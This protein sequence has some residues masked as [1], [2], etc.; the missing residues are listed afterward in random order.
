M[1]AFPA[2]HVLTVRFTVA[3]PEGL[4]TTLAATCRLVLTSCSYLG[5]RLPAEI[6]LPYR[7]SVH[8]VIL[9]LQ[10]SYQNDP[11]HAPSASQ[12]SPSHSMLYSTGSLRQ[13]QGRSKP[14]LRLLHLDRPL[15]RLAKEDP[16]TYNLFIEGVALLAWNIAWLCR[17]QGG[18]DITSWEDACNIGKNLWRLLVE[19]TRPD[20]DPTISTKTAPVMIPTTDAPA[21]ENT[22]PPSQPVLSCPVLGEYSH[23][24]KHMNL[25]GPQGLEWMRAWNAPSLA[26]IIDGLKSH[27]LTEMSGAEWELLE[28]REWNEEREDEH[29]ILVGGTSSR[30]AQ[31]GTTGESRTRLG[32]MTVPDAGA[33]GDASGIDSTKGDRMENRSEAKG[34]TKVRERGAEGQV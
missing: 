23:D 32:A 3:H 4:T 22:G 13:A 10:S 31:T 24:R 33:V 14:K 20:H 27:L 28:E 5:V 19:P 16:A 8:P 34:W 2:D 25:A 29:A 18:P 30:V 17:S 11:D 7:E 6:S 15:L 9:S 1:R 21:S 12:K 26:R